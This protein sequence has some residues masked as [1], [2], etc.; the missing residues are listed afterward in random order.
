MAEQLTEE[1]IAEF[2]EA[3]SLFDK[4]GDGK[5]GVI[6]IVGRVERK[7][8][9]TTNDWVYVGSPYCSGTHWQISIMT[10]LHLGSL[11]W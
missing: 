11:G 9:F 8:Y 5:C 4:D 7:Q 2:K 1:Q 3:F 6:S 10:L